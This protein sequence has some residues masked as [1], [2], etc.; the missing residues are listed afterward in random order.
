VTPPRLRQRAT[1][2][3]GGDGERGGGES[4]GGESGGGGG[5]GGGGGFVQ[6]TLLPC[7]GNPAALRGVCELAGGGALRGAAALLTPATLANELRRL[8][9]SC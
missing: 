9:G 2:D 6:V 7:A 5:G 4:G 8:G 3:G 1:D